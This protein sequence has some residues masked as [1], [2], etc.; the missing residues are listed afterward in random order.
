MSNEVI[1][2]T[3][4]KRDLAL[5][6]DIERTT[7]R[8]RPPKGQRQEIIEI[9]ISTFNFHNGRVEKKESIFVKP[10]NSKV[11]EFCTELTGITQ[12][13]LDEN[14][15]TIQ[16]AMRKL[17]KRYESNKRMWMSWGESDRYYIQLDCDFYGIS[18]PMH[19]G[20]VDV[21][22]LF[23]SKYN[24]E[25]SL[26]TAIQEVGLEFEGD[27]HSGLA[28]AYNTGLLYKSLIGK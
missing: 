8:G 28:D 13:F 27:E 9:G 19:L 10:Q 16:E 3:K 18:N 24:Y 14:G 5:V 1:P 4:R 20:Y 6:L 11:S 23:I 21:R 12:E 26:G 25:P 2:L 15:V 7:W 17:W 22:D